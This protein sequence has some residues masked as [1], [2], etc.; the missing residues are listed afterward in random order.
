MNCCFNCE[1]IVVVVDMFT[2]Y[3]AFHLVPQLAL[4]LERNRSKATATVQLEDSKEVLTLSYD[5]IC[6][7][8]TDTSHVE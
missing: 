1:I 6:Q 3:K 4:I 2:V 5:D 8:I 7:C